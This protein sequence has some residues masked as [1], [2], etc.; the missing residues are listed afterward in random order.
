MPEK[1]ISTIYLV[2]IALAL[3]AV[4]VIFSLVLKYGWYIPVGTGAV[5]LFMS[6]YSM[7]RIR[8][9]A[10]PDKKVPMMMTMVATGLSVIGFMVG[11]TMAL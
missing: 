9:S 8:F 3:G 6:T 10:I 11:L 2:F 7:S 1:K 5:G 4:S